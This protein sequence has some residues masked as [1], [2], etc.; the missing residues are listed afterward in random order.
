MSSTADLLDR[1]RRFVQAEAEAQYESLSSQWAHPIGERVSNGWAIEGLDVVREE[2]D[3]IR[4]ACDT[5]ISRFREGDLLVLHQEQESPHSERALHVELQYDG[6][7]EIEVSLIKGNPYLLAAEPRGWIAD[8]DWFDASSFYLNALD[9]V[10]D[11]L[12]GRSIILPLLGGSLA[13]KMDYA[14]YERAAQAAFEAGLNESQVE[15][16]AQGY[17]A[18]LLHL[19]QGPPGTGKTWV[20]A[21]LARL[22][23]EDVQPSSP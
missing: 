19:I 3:I 9:E 10:A 11:T 13:P 20:L 21:H 23:A 8:Q 7:T 2:H 5:N 16:V 6:E 18:D 4:L 17:A 1:L 22:L 12:R 14:R 15:A